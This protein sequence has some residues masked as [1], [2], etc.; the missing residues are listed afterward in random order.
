[1]SPP[2]LIYINPDQISG[3]DLQTEERLARCHW[4]RGRWT[5]RRRP[6]HCFPFNMVG[7]VE[8]GGANYFFPSLFCLPPKPSARVKC[9]G[10]IY[11]RPFNV[12]ALMSSLFKIPFAGYLYNTLFCGSQQGF[13]RFGSAEAPSHPF[14]SPFPHTTSCAVAFWTRFKQVCL[15]YKKKKDVLP[16]QLSFGLCTVRGQRRSRSTC[17]SI[18]TYF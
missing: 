1:M 5:C 14:Q 18:R 11:R 12:T 10:D 15:L 16:E 7:W 17:S 2:L 8:C 3:S 9:L 13:H 4:A 6:E